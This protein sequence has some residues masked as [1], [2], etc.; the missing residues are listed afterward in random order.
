[1]DVLIGFGIVFGY[2]GGYTFKI[3][4]CV[5]VPGFSVFN[6]L[7]GLCLSMGKA[8]LGMV[9][10]L[11]KFPP[12]IRFGSDVAAIIAVILYIIFYNILK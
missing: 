9:E 4:G 5:P 12:A 6:V 2:I 8:C 1:M 10:K 11:S 3:I 7:G